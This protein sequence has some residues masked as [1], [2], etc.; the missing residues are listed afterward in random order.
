MIKSTTVIITR[1]VMVAGGLILVTIAALYFIFIAV[2]WFTDQGNKADLTKEIAALAPPPTC[3]EET[4][5]YTSLSLD[6][7][8]SL[9]ISY[10][11]NTTGRVAYD[12]IISELTKRGYKERVDYSKGDGGLF[13]SF[14]YATDKH[15]AD[16]NFGTSTP[17]SRTQM[18]Q[19]QIPTISLD[20][21]KNP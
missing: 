7:K 9:H 14:N 3:Q 2:P 16:Y 17:E 15:E 4:R 10:K 8:S 18:E 13:Y 11:C 12:F 6:T 5:E 1:L 19:S 20:L 21:I